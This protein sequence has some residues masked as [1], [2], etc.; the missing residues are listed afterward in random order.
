MDLARHTQRAGY[1]VVGVAGHGV[2]AVTGMGQYL[3]DLWGQR[4]QWPHRI[5]ETYSELANYGQALLGRAEREV[6]RAPG[7]AP[8]VGEATGLVADED[9]LPI[10]HY[11]DRNAADITGRLAE[12]S[13]HDLH[14]V[15][16]YETRHRARITILRRINE[17]RGP[18]PWAGYDEMSVEEIL[19]RMRASSSQE[20]AAVLDYEQRHKQRRTITAHTPGG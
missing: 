7:A 19:P 2:D 20:Q 12:L 17:L 9:D 16:G 6:R 14:L 11:E 18:Q 1:A 10:A 5:G 4:A 3:A 15:E 8:V 13:Q